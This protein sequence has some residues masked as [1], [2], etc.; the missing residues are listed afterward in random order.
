MPFGKGSI[1]EIEEK[2]RKGIYDP[3]PEHVSEEIKD[4]IKKCLVL[5]P[6]ERPS[7]FEILQS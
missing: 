5:N 7:V 3:I 4:I 6:R 1:G 2:I